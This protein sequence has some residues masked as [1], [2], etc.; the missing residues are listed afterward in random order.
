MKLSLKCAQISLLLIG[1]T[2]SN[3]GQFCTLF[4]ILWIVEGLF[5]GTQSI[6]RKLGRF[7]NFQ[8]IK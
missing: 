5:C 7:N 2:L 4:Y 3:I 6:E 1:H 8:L